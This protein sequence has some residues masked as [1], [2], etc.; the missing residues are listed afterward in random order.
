MT[1][2]LASEAAAAL[3]PYPPGSKEREEFLAK[4]GLENAANKGKDPI[5]AQRLQN[6]RNRWV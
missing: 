1:T 2:T 6:L 5:P 3:A 4:M